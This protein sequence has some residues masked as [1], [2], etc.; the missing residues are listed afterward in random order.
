MCCATFSLKRKSFPLGS[1]VCVDENLLDVPLD[2]LASHSTSRPVYMMYPQKG[3]KH[4]LHKSIC[5][6]NAKIN[7]D[8][9]LPYV[10]YDSVDNWIGDFQ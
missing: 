9:I 8:W 5:F 2:V 3:Y 1:Y 6:E 4:K 7:M 10:F